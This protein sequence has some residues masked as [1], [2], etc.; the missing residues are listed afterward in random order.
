MLC[1]DVQMSLINGGF[2][3]V[4]VLSLGCDDS[5]IGEAFREVLSM[6]DEVSVVDNDRTCYHVI[7]MCHL[8]FL[9]S[10]VCDHMSILGVV[11]IAGSI[12][13]YEETKPLKRLLLHCC[14]I[15][16]SIIVCFVIV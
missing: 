1:D 8:C 4:S 10:Y 16:F 13:V 9:F 5:M 12:I 15:F 7:I 3:V 14:N 6:L 11:L 2:M